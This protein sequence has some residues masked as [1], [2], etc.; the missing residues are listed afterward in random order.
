MTT[1]RTRR[2]LLCA[3]AA[4]TALG[5]PVPIASAQPAQ[6]EV[7]WSAVPANA[8]GPDGRRVVNLELAGGETVTEHVAVT[9]HSARPVTF[10]V[11]ANDGYLTD[12]G[13]FD[14]RAADVTPTDGGSWIDVPDTVT[15]PGGATTVVPVSVTA[16]E[17]AT[18]GDHPA[19]VT[20]S[21]DTLSGQVR[22]RNRVGVRFNIRVTGDLRA[23]FTVTDV[24]ATY[25]RSWNPFAAG[26]VIVRY[27]VA[28]DGNVRAAADTAITTSNP[29]GD[30]TWTDPAAPRAREV[31][32]GGRRQ[33]ETRLTDHWPL[34][35]ISTTVSV[36]PGAIDDTTAPPTAAPV[37]ATVT[38]WAFP[39]PQALLP[40]F[41]AL[42]WL[43]VRAIRR[44]RRR[45]LAR[46]LAEAKAEGRAEA[47]RSGQPDP[48]A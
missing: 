9:N 42:L 11:D 24:H 17:Q 25:E 26:T 23:A 13:L 21:L 45:R 18:P 2:L 41:V 35:R 8:T 3:A 47:A 44:Q 12:K 4:A 48:T 7:T 30:D 10:V 40:A 28:N 38:T 27:T 19:G 46:M 6:G 32:P 22:V 29:F 36:T 43:A 14:M 15:V 33:F 20:A 37:T 5:G 34:G 39:L 31:L 1:T 16:P